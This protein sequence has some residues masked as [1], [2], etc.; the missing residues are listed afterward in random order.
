MTFAEVYAKT[1]KNADSLGVPLFV[2]DIGGSMGLFIGASMLTVLEVID[3]ILIQI[4]VF[5]TKKKD[6][7]EQENDIRSEVYKV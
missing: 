6:D 4:P 5:K 2:G 7:T 1:P 3:L